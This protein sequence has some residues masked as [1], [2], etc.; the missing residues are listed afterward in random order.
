MLALSRLENNQVTQQTDQHYGVKDSL[1]FDNY[2]EEE[3][4][5]SLLKE[6]ILSKNKSTNTK[7]TKEGKTKKYYNGRYIVL[8]KQYI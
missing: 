8:I 3:L 5:E 1:D 4:N 6:E 7:V 2:Y